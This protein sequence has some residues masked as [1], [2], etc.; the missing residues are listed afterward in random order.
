MSW[1]RK[2]L[3]K[4]LHSTGQKRCAKCGRK[5]LGHPQD[6]LTP[7]HLPQSLSQLTNDYSKLL[8]SVGYTCGRCGSVLCVGCLPSSEHGS[9]VCP[10]CGH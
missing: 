6:T 8:S 5:L 1:L 7:L 10:K 3:G 9:I 2:W 4:P